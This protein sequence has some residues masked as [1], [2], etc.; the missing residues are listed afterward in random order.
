ML[1]SRSKFRPDSI[2]GRS[3]TVEIANGLKNWA[4]YVFFGANVPETEVREAAVQNL[5][6]MATVGSSHHVAVAA[7]LHLP[8]KWAY[9]YVMPERLPGSDPGFIAPVDTIP[10]ANS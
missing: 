10:N 3:I 5:L 4:L 9:R 1:L 2:S 7:Q 8:G 6:Q